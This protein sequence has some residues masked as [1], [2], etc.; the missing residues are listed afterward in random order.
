MYSSNQNPLAHLVTSSKQAPYLV[1]FFT[2]KI[3]LLLT[4]NENP[5]F[6]LTSSFCVLIKKPHF[7]HLQAHSVSISNQNPF[8]PIF[9]LTSSFC[10]HIKPKPILAH[11]FTYKLILWAHQTKTHSCPSF[12][13]QAHSVSTSNQNPFF[14]LHHSVLR[15]DQNPFFY[16]QAHSMSSWNQTQ[17]FTTFS[18]CPEWVRRAKCRK[19]LK[20]KL[21]LWIPSRTNHKIQ[22]KFSCWLFLICSSHV[23]ELG[24]GPGCKFQFSRTFSNGVTNFPSEIAS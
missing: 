18:I 2:Y 20:L 15:S 11:F 4:S 16:L 1:H 5:F 14:H 6:P 24:N 23:Q 12:H 9:S 10:E 8:W 19:A 21:K 3:V 22:N 17:F 13:L 7:F